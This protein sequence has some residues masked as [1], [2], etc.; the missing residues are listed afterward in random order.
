MLEPKKIDPL[1]EGVVSPQMKPTCPHC[2]VD[3]VPIAANL[4]SLEGA[5]AV[6]F[7]CGLC[8]KTLGVSALPDLQKRL[9]NPSMIVR[10][11]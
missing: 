5:M 4:I 6:V 1:T 2:N 10:P 3:P 9:P 7:F 8:R 11:S